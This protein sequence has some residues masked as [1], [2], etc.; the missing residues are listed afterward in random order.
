MSGKPDL[1]CLNSD[2]SSAYVS[3]IPII[4]LRHVLFDPGEE[5]M[6]AVLGLVEMITV[7]LP[8]R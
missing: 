3:W 6:L 2:G 5:T 8:L 4:V 1:T 7:R